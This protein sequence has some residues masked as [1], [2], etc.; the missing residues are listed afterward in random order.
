MWIMT[1]LNTIACIQIGISLVFHQ[2]LLHTF[3]SDCLPGFRKLPRV[4]LYFFVWVFG[5]FTEM[6]L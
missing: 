6:L 5:P 4:P 3:V 2:L 1:K